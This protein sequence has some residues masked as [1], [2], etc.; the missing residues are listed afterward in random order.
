VLLIGGGLIGAGFGLYYGLQATG[1]EPGMAGNWAQVRGS[2]RAG[3]CHLAQRHEAVLL[4]EAPAAASLRLATGAA[5][6]PARPGS[7]VQAALVP[8]C[9]LRGCGDGCQLL[10]PCACFPA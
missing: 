1:M 9:E 2:A 5:T 3:P 7:T 4:S 6:V 10:W 8:L